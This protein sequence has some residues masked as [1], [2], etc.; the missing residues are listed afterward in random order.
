[1]TA[2]FFD[3]RIK[4]FKRLCEEKV[5]TLSKNGEPSIADI[6][7]KASVAI[8][9][10]LFDLIEKHGVEIF[11]GPK[12]S[13]QGNGNLFEKC[14]AEFLEQTFL[15]LGHLRPGKWHIRQS[16]VS[17]FEFEQYGHLK[18]LQTLTKK[19]GHIAAIIGNNYD[20]L[21]DVII[22]RDPEPDDEIN[23]GAVLID[24]Q[25][26]R[27]TVI[28]EKNNTNPLL[29]ASISCKF[30][31]RTDRAQ[32]ART[33][34]LSF[35]RNRKGRAPHICL[36]TAEPMPSRLAS[37]ALGTGDV[38]C[39]YH[40]ALDELLQSIRDLSEQDDRGGFSATYEMLQIMIDGK[41][42]KDISDLPLDLAV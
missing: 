19:D 29:H 12:N 24:D 1:M 40:V 7:N 14:I 27:H 38:D 6:A 17:I 30:T 18:E 20:I 42:L 9:K 36:V 41:R 16:H 22:S 8:S 4:L 2:K 5:F 11:T 3:A 23:N 10:G 39:V 28:R 37:I 33:E 13:G 32:N 25:E 15:S 31:L 21:P 35:I 26:A 34:A